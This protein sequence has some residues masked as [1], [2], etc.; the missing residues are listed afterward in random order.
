MPEKRRETRRAA[1]GIVQVRC[2]QPERK[3]IEG[4]LID[5]SASGFR[6]AHRDIS[7]QTGQVVEFSHKEATGT[8]RVMWNRIHEQSV[9]TG[10]FVL[11]RE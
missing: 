6:M 11:G 10:F 1:T 8:A 7:L 5:V 4:R 3:K 9:E 2:S